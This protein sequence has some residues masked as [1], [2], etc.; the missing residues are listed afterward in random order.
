MTRSG[1]REQE[2]CNLEVQDLRQS[3][4]GVLCLHVRRGKGCKT[5]AIPYGS[6]D[7]CLAVVDKWLALVGIEQGPVFRGF[8]KGGRRLRPGAMNPRLIQRMLKAYPIT[9]GGVMV[10]VCPHDLRRTYARIM[11]DL[12]MDTLAISQNLGHADIKTTQGYIGKLGMAKR[13]PKRAFTFDLSTLDRIEARER[14]EG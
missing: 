8:Y 11:Y 14:R 12:G 9:H 5:R 6:L 4:D 7:G 3:A 10:K 1:I 2:V 13:Q